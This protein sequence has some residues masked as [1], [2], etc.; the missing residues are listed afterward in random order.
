MKLKITDVQ[1]EIY[2]HG[3]RAKIH[4]WH[5]LEDNETGIICEGNPTFVENMRNIIEESN[6]KKEKWIFWLKEYGIKAAHPDDGFHN[7]IERYFSFFYPYFDNGV[8]INDKVALGDYDNFIVK[9][10][11]DIKKSFFGNKKYYYK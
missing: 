11:I 4:G 3:G 2:P 6:D 8:K 10:I 5:R 1:K 9:K 7:R